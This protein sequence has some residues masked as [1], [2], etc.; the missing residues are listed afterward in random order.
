MKA[1]E[2]LGLMGSSGCG[3]TTLCK[4]I[5][6]EESADVGSKI[7]FGNIDLCNRYASLEHGIVAS[8]P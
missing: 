8:C 3:K 2:I 7:M 5:Q 6:H 4:I 1:G